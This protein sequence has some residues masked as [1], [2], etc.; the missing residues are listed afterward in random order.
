MKNKYLHFFLPILFFTLL[1]SSLS[2]ANNDWV[3]TAENPKAFIE[4]KGQFHTDDPSDKVLYAYDNGSTVIFFTSTGIKYRFL[5]VVRGEK[6]E[7]EIA[8][9]RMLERAREKQV[10]SSEEWKKHEDLEHKVD[11]KID[12]VDFFWENINQNFQILPTEPTPDYH[13]YSFWENGEVKNVNFINAYKKLIYKN[14]YPN[15]DIEYIIHPLEGL[16]YTLILHPGADASV[17]K[18]RYDKAKLENGELFIPTKFGDMVEHSPYTFYQN[19]TSELIGSSFVENSN[20][21]SFKLDAYDATRTV[22]IDPW[23]QTPTLSNSNCVWECEKDGAGNVYIIGGDMPMKLRKYNSTGAMQWT[24]NTPW[25]T[26]EGG[27]GG[28]LGTLATDNS[29]NSYVTNG[30]TA[31]LE[32][33]NSSGS[34]V[35]SVSG[36]NF[37]EY[38]NIS[39]N[40]DQTKLIVGG[41]RLTGMPSPTG[42]GVIFDINTSNGS[43]NGVQTVGKTRSSVV[44][45]FPVVD[46]EEVRSMT[47]SRGAK[48]YFLTLD[49]IG[50]IGQNFSA[51]PTPGNLF[52]I[53]HTYGFGYKCENYRPNN[54][55]SGMKA[56]KANGNY[57]YTQNG[58]TIQQRSLS[59]GAVLASATIPG[60]L[61]ASSGGFN[62]A[63]N[64]GIDIDSCGNVYVGSGNAV[65]K[66]DANLNQLSSTSLPFRV[67]DVAVSYNGDVIVCGGTGNSS[68]TSRTGYVQSINMTAC[69]PMV[70]Y[71]CDA[72]ICPVGPYCTTDAPV[73]LTPVVAGGTW[74]GPGIT[75]ASTGAFSPSVAGPGTHTII[76]TLACGSDSTIIE[77][78]CCGAAINPV[79]NVCV[80][81]PALTL[82]AAQSGGT[83]SGPGITNASAG[84][85]DPGTAGT[86]THTIVY[87]LASCGSDSLDISV[88]GCVS[89]TACQEQNGDI[90][91]TSGSAPYTWSNQTTTQNCSACAF[92]CAFP[93]GC[94]VNVTSWTSFGTGTTIT[95][96]GTYPVKLTDNNGDSLIITS[97]SSLPACSTTSCPALTITPSNVVNVSCQGL[98]DGSFDASTSGGVSPWDY[99]LKNSGG[100]TVATFTNNAGTQSFTGLV[101]GV[102]TLYAFDDNNCPDTITVTITEPSGGSVT[103]N[104]GPDQTICSNSAIL[105][106]NTPSSGTGTWTIISGPGTVT[107][108]S[109]PT[110]AVTGLGVGVTSLQWTITSTCAT[111]SD[112]VIITNTGGGP[113]VAIVSSTNVT[114]NGAGDGS[115][116]ASATGGSGTLTYAWTPSGGSATAASGLQA[117]T[118]TISVTDGGGCTGIET[119]TITE[120]SAI[121]VSVVATP[122]GCGNTGSV[123]ATASGGTGALSYLWNTGESTSSVSNLG[124]GTYTVTV[125][126]DN[127]CTATDNGTVTT[128]G[129][130]IA[131]ISAGDTIGIG[132]SIQL[133]ANGGSSYTWSPSDGLDCIT[134]RTPNAS[135]TETTVYCVIVAD[136]G[137]ADTACVTI[138]VSGEDCETNYLTAGSVYVPNAFTPNK[139]ELNDVFKPVVNCVH[140]YT[141]VVFDRWGEKLFETTDI[142]AGWNGTFKGSLCKPDVYVYKVT[143][144]DDPRDNYHSY[145]GRVVLLK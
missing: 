135:P 34:M 69:D 9:E 105:A 104:A 63:G 79:G 67:Y 123:A 109:S 64:S 144:I 76:Y 118:Y 115:A 10:K 11:Y 131:T 70:L 90:T 12:Y 4:N 57:V 95:P 72:T 71:C 19:N 116:T 107:T 52:A 134:C 113:V 17:V 127:A 98:S 21:I 31:A 89:L 27:T 39:F 102:Y 59:T 60:G 82:T 96:S 38:W 61:S 129:G 51:C 99:T 110:S 58:T 103:V 86:G 80:G 106:G 8:R 137:C 25:D 124:A 35:Y 126:D 46:I 6:D 3:S 28:W 133:T 53:N 65:I 48:Y 44:F 121:T 145:I 37:D 24:Y 40:C 141:F 140:N 125:T 49:T 100:T 136:N 29:G 142:D 81:D 83:W 77:V 78:S 93:P 50:A 47:P 111:G 14:I 36:G 101:A 132:E 94:A 88:G 112:T 56:I 84:T 33:I 130:V 75:N 43:V 138:V 143:F 92:G 15:I 55:N 74:S 87:T 122:A 20:S 119:V 23:V 45:G 91:A 66:Y 32:K 42:D 18:M 5:E 85:F 30:S 97:L 139:D 73:T 26:T 7:R 128:V 13:S 117:G 54:G 68:N 1:I 22:C 120:P 62:Q 16:K 2:F 108:P 41:T 114:C